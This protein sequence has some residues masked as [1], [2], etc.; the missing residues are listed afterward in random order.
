MSAGQIAVGIIG[1][2]R[3]GWNIHA[4]GLRELPD[5]F[6]VVA[7][8]DP[9]EARRVEAA[10][11]LGV[12]TYTEPRQLIADDR[13]ELVVVATPSHTHVPIALIALQAGKHVVL[14]KPMAQRPEEIDLMAA[15]AESAGRVLTCFQ[16]NRLEPSFLAVRQ[17]IESGRI[18]EVV[19]VRRAIHRFARRADW[20]TLRSH[21]GGELSNKVSHYLDQ[22]L[23]LIGDTPTSVSAD[24]R[25]TVSA[26]D[27]EDHVKLTLRPE[28]GPVLEVESS[29]TVAL[30]QDSWF[31]VGTAGG[32]A[33]SQSTLRVRWFDP[34]ALPAL[35]LRTGAAEGREYGT[36]ESIDW[37]EETV[38]VG[39]SRRT[40]RYYRRLYATLREGA[41]LFV[42]PASV[43][44][45]VEI[46]TRAR[47]R[48]GAPR[49]RR[50]TISTTQEL[51]AGLR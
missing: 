42:T 40:E 28:H 25:H 10:T 23:L 1:L 6:R 4:A 8:A 50:S 12:T 43:R 39:P 32:I 9:L 34:A 30:P 44:R 17:I 16:N 37:S 47:T 26:G 45:Q 13:V 11:E 18:G 14:E 35:V 2:G 19:L 48:S 36:D 3:S 24:L 41:D 5:R 27:A 49:E 38:A 31:V 7:V 22:L 46:L 29:A 15:V 33:G 51:S 21:G 20:Q